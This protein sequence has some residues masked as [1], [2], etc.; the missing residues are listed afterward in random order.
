MGDRKVAYFLLGQRFCVLHYGHP[1]L[2]LDLSSLR[3]AEAHCEL[4]IKPTDDAN[5][6]S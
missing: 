6:T 2:G 3:R 4:F 5:L 1:G